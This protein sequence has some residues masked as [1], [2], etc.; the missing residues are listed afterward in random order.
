MAGSEPLIT[1]NTPHQGKRNF[2][3]ARRSSS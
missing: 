3:A 2:C 1:P